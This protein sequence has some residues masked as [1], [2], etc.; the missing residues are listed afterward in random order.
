MKYGEIYGCVE[1]YARELVPSDITYSIIRSPISES[2]YL[3]LTYEN[4]TR[5]VRFS[6]H[7]SKKYITVW[8]TKSTRHSKIEN[9][10]RKEIK[11]MRMHYIRKTIA[12]DLSNDK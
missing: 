4:T 1:K 11:A 6:G 8:I 3:N 9:A 2:V 12:G 10:I 5:I 7:K